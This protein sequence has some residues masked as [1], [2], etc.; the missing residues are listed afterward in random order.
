MAQAEGSDM[1][2]DDEPMQ[3]E[4]TDEDLAALMAP[5]FNPG[6]MDEAQRAADE[7]QRAAFEASELNDSEA[8]E[9]DDDDGDEDEDD[10]DGG[11]PI[12]MEE[13]G[14]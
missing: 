8:E 4:I 2:S 6:A 10:D 9:E 13:D 12:S 11:G 5:E 3:E 14:H 1:G 7:A